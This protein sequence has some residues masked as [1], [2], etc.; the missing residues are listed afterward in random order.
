MRLKNFIYETTHATQ[1]LQALKKDTMIDFYKVQKD[2]QRRNFIVSDKELIRI[3][4]KAFKDSGI[5]FRLVSKSEKGYKKY[6]AGG[7]L[8]NKGREA[9]D[10]A[11]WTVDVIGGFSEYFKRFAKPGKEAY[12]RD[13]DLNEFLRE[14]FDLLSHEMIHAGQVLRS[15]GLAFG[16]TGSTMPADGNI[17]KYLSNPAEIE[18]YALQSAVEYERSGKSPMYDLYINTFKKSSKVLKRFLKKFA[19]YRE[20][21]KK[22]GTVKKLGK[23]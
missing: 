4:N 3:L 6:I 9:P 20:Q 19:E 10:W 8:G 13:V 16:S 18:A 17:I 1:M 7:Q 14:L 15:Q 5:F 11:V 2:L 23:E 21:V 22:S 12:F